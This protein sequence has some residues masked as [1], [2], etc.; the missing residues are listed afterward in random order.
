MDLKNITVTGFQVEP[1]HLTAVCSACGAL[2]GDIA[3]HDDWHS[4]NLENRSQ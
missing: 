2:L 3:Q 4:A 1:Y